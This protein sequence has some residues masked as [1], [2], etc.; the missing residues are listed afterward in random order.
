VKTGD[1]V[2]DLVAEPGS[3][4]NPNPMKPYLGIDIGGSGI[5]GAPVDLS[6]GLLAGERHRIATP[7]PALTAPV[8][9]TVRAIAEHFPNVSGPIGCTFPGI[10]ISGR[11]YTAANLDD[12]W[13]G[14][15]AAEAFATACG[16]PVALINDADAAGLAEARFGAG[17]GHKGVVLV[18][19]LGTGIGSALLH[20]GR[21]VPNTE[22]GHLELNGKIVEKQAS[23]RARKEKELSFKKWAKV[24]NRYLSHLDRILAP[25]L[26]VIGGGISKQFDT[27]GPLLRSRADLVPAALRNQAGIVGAALWAAGEATD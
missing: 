26:V 17:A 13:I 15:D 3:Y 19:T 27:F 11:I 16:R 18:L 25:D 1:V 7:Q 6:S 2:A 21:L 12:Q 10:V 24:L 5:K 22:L 14:V 20:N 8:S 23:N 9:E 4:R